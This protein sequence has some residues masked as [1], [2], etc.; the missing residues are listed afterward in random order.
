M[1]DI[2]NFRVIQIK[3]LKATKIRHERLKAISISVDNKR[4]KSI[5]EPL[6]CSMNSTGQAEAMAVSYCRLHM[7]PDPTGFGRLP[8]GDYVAMIPR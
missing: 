6:H 2:K 8:N 3:H 7:W 1:S 5:I 4:I